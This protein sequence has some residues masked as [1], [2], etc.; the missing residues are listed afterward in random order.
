MTEKLPIFASTFEPS[1]DLAA[2]DVIVTLPEQFMRSSLDSL[3][4]EIGGWLKIWLYSVTIATIG[5]I[6]TLLLLPKYYVFVRRPH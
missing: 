4:L 6:I 3:D 1:T 2:S 5:L